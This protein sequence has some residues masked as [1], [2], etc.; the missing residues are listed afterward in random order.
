M[1]LD[2][3]FVTMATILMLRMRARLTDTMARTGLPAVSLSA[4]ARGITVSVAHSIPV[5]DTIADRSHADLVAADTLVA[6]LK[7]VALADAASKDVAQPPA[8]MVDRFEADR[9][10]AAVRFTAEAAS[11]VVAD[12]AAD[13]GNGRPT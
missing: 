7:V 1:W 2:L 6:A 4:R 11:T 5:T 13:A 10:E 9:Y 8:S 12:P 3:R